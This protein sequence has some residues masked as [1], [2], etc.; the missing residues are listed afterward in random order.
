M[1][2][3]ARFFTVE[4]YHEAIEALRRATYQLQPDGKPCACCGDSDHQAFECHH[5]PLVMMAEAE[6]L[7]DEIDRIHEI[8][9]AKEG[10]TS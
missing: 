1:I 9:H 5:N 10:R 4:E 7:T 3:C 2:R 8:A 6:R